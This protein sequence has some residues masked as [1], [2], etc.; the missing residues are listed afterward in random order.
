[1]PTT[2]ETRPI[3][4]ARAVLEEISRRIGKQEASRR[5]GVNPWYIGIALRRNI[6]VSVEVLGRFEKVL[7]DA[8]ANGEDNF[9]P[10]AIRKANLVPG[11]PEARAKANAARIEKWRRVRKARL[12][13]EANQRWAQAMVAVERHH[14]VINPVDTSEPD[15]FWWHTTG[16]EV[17]PRWG[18]EMLG[19]EF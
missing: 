11:T 6:G 16:M 19:D 17:L 18:A 7:E 4:E 1:M 2:I 12:S 13:S 14:E 5:A 15:K 9:D 8:I 10:M 3:E